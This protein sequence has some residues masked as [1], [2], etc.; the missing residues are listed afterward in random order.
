MGLITPSLVTSVNGQRGEV[1]LTPENILAAP[2]SPIAA[3]LISRSG[4]AAVQKPWYGK[5]VPS[6]IDAGGRTIYSKGTYVIVWDDALLYAPEDA[7]VIVN[8]D[9]DTSVA[10]SEVLIQNPWTNIGA[11]VGQ[12]LL[13]S[14]PSFGT[15]IYSNEPR[16]GA[17]SQL[18]LSHSTSSLALGGQTYH[19]GFPFDLTPNLSANN[20]V[21]QFPF[22]ASVVAAYIGAFTGATAPA[23]QIN[24]SVISLRNVTNSTDFL[25]TNALYYGT[26]SNRMVSVIEDNLTIPVSPSKEYAIKIDAPTFTASPSIRHYVCLYI[27]RKN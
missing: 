5:Y 25:L 18:T 21:F 1:N 24:P 15:Y 10:W 7:Y 17:P 13:Q 27:E 11:G 19:F 4:L 20:R 16:L 3:V 9:N 12:P 22:E 8:T 6:G 14:D 26:L 23:G 2:E